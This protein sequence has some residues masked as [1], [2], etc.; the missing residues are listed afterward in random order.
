MTSQTKFWAT[1]YCVDVNSFYSASLEVIGAEVTNSFTRHIH[2]YAD[3]QIII[4]TSCFRKNCKNW[5]TSRTVAK[6]IIGIFCCN[7][8]WRRLDSNT[9]SVMSHN[10][11][12][13]IVES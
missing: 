2:G 9:D 6:T 11:Y 8:K 4:R 10:T 5:I 13:N 3:F 12:L 7:L 1:L